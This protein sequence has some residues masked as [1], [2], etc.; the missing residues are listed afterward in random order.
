[1]IGRGLWLMLA[2]LWAVPVM[3]IGSTELSGGTV[4]HDSAS[5][6]AGFVLIPLLV[7]LLIG[8]G[9]YWAVTGFF[10]D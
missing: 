2:T 8:A 3:L 6:A 4:I 1:M 9:L 7:L 5:V 10:G